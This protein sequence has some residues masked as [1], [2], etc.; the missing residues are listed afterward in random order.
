[1]K[2]R[3]LLKINSRPVITI[4]PND[5]VSAAVQKLS[6]YDY[7]SL[8]VCNDK[9]ELVGIVTE[10]DI[11]RKCFKSIDACANFKVQDVM[12]KEVAVG[13]P[14]DDLEYAI[15]AMKQKR[16]RHLPIVDNHKKVVG[17]VSMRD[18]LDVELKESQAELRYAG[19]VTR[20]PPRR[21]V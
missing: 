7:G 11:V 12:T 14:D 13:I 20:R 19:L 8:P 17:M 5:T 9:G 6:E 21:I 18:L 1:M 3:D 4:G 15:S 16:I 2:I 10:R